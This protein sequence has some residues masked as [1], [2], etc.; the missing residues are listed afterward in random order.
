M[1]REEAIMKAKKHK[2]I[3]DE[4]ETPEARR[5]ERRRMGLDDQGEWINNGT[6]FDFA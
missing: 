2:D 4:P 5:Q 6:V 3:D 1:T